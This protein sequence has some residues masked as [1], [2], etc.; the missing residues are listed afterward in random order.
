MQY[1]GRVLHAMTINGKANSRKKILLTGLQ[2]AREWV[3]GMAAMVFMPHQLPD[4]RTGRIILA[5][6]SLLKA[7]VLLQYIAENLASELSR[8][9][10]TSLIHQY[11]YL[12]IPV[13]NPDGLAVRVVAHPD[14][15][16]C[17]LC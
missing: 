8:T 12:V 10:S 15:Y 7:S 4:L 2:H 14:L 1:E 6:G 11:E 16:P 3:S 9:E 13:V 17:H 5:C